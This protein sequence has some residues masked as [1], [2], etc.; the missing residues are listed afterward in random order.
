VRRL[1][2]RWFCIALLLSAAGCSPPIGW[3]RR[4][5]TPTPS[6]HAEV[7]IW[8]RGVVV[9]WHAVVV[10]RD[11]ITGI[12][13]RRSASCDRC[14]RSLPRSAVDSIRLHYV[15]P[16]VTAIVVVLGAQALVFEATGSC[17]FVIQN[18]GRP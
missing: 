1:M 9:R 12:P 7:L 5:L 3:R 14:R 17:F 15:S 10:T 6:A 8:S 11:S 16:V 13:F 18:C 2:M 4:D